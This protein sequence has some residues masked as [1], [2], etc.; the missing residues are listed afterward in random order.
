MGFPEDVDMKA[1][2]DSE[3]SFGAFLHFIAQFKNRTV[4]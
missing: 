3:F 4:F 2:G 1:P